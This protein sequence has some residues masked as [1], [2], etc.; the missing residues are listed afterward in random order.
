MATDVAEGEPLGVSVRLVPVTVTGP[1]LDSDALLASTS[2]KD[3]DAPTQP[4]GIE[5]SAM[6]V[7]T[8]AVTVQEIEMPDNE[9]HDETLALAPTT[10]VVFAVAPAATAMPGVAIAAAMTDASAVS[11]RFMS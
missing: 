3:N 6:L 9:P 11:R 5:A 8:L 2:V 10:F 4:E 1:M 7:T